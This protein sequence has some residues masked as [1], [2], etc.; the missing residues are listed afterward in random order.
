MRECSVINLEYSAP[1]LSSPHIPASPSRLVNK[2]SKCSAISCMSKGTCCS[3]HMDSSSSTWVGAQ[4][5]NV[6]ATVMWQEV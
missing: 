2:M 6:R 4:K 1:L 3:V 5:M